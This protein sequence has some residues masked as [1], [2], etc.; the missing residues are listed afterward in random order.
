MALLGFV[1]S[2]FFLSAVSPMQ[3]ARMVG[4]IE[5]IGASQ[6]LW[7]CATQ[8]HTS[9]CRA[10]GCPLQVFYLTPTPFLL[11]AFTKIAQSA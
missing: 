3:D 9:G 2:F 11:H 7:F 10:V 8:I 5:A 1:H 6:F 4:H